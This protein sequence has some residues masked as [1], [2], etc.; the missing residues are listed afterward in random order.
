MVRIGPS[1]VL[2]NGERFSLKGRSIAEIRHVT[3][4]TLMTSSTIVVSS[5]VALIIGAE[6]GWTTTNGTP[7]SAGYTIGASALLSSFIIFLPL[8]MAKS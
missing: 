3:E 4:D 2:E 5:V 8:G 1:R 7:F 6:M